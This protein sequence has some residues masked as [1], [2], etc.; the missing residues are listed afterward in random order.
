MEGHESLTIK[1]FLSF[2]LQ[3]IFNWKM[4]VYLNCV[5]RLPL[6]SLVCIEARLCY[7]KAWHSC[8]YVCL[9]QFF[10]VTKSSLEKETWW[11][12]HRFHFDNIQRKGKEKQNIICPFLNSVPLRKKNRVNV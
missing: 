4:G 6:C 12:G 1:D 8:S 7:S 2:L 3:K 9:G 10:L 11:S 5:L